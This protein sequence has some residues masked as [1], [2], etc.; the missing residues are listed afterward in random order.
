MICRV[1]VE[2]RGSY[3]FT[4]QVLQILAPYLLKNKLLQTIAVNKQVLILLENSSPPFPPNSPYIKTSNWKNKIGTRTCWFPIELIWKEWRNKILNQVRF[5]T[6]MKIKRLSGTIERECN[7]EWNTAMTQSV[8]S[9]ACL[10]DLKAARHQ[11]LWLCLSYPRQMQDFWGII[12]PN[13]HR[14]HTLNLFPQ[15]NILSHK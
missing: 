12:W 4:F 13:C 6:E 2:D 3:K 7:V 15:I 9:T 10:D 5:I 1:F 14:G 11:G 8:I